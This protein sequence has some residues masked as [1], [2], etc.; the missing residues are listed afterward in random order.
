MKTV[1]SVGQSGKGFCLLCCLVYFMSYLTRMNYAASLAEIQE[2]LA[3]SKNLASLPVTGSF[4]SYG[5][6]QLLCGFLGDRWP[7]GKMIFAGLLS[8]CACN[9]VVALCPS[10]GVILPVWCMNGLFQAMLWPPLVRIMAERLDAEAYERCCMLVTMSASAGAVFVYLLVPVCIRFADWRAAFLLPAAA[11]TASAFLWLVRCGEN[12]KSG[13]RQ[14]RMPREKRESSQLRL[15]GLLLPAALLPVLAAIILQGGLRDGI[16]TW[17]PVYTAETFQMTSASAILLTAVLP[18]V[19]IPGIS[20]AS[21]L[22]H[23]KKNELTV[24][25]AFFAAGTAA[26]LFLYGQYQSGPGIS[27]VLMTLITGCMYGVNF[28]LIS[29]APVRFSRFGKVSTISG[30]LNAATYVG[31]A[32]SAWL[33][34][35][36]SETFGWGVVIG[37]WAAASGLGGLLCFSFRGKWAGFWKRSGGKG[38]GKSMEK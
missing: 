34:G 37:V 27:A 13:G 28:L 25:A 29:Q 36:L 33:F 16:T 11:G 17:M 38:T 9:F 21:F 18:A 14:S 35:V 15:A 23:R 20:L 10:I 8:T 12:D 31:S 30:I 4:F 26:S 5:A 24:S 7:P 32:L 22:F 1:R 3:I 19:S 6:G 2:D